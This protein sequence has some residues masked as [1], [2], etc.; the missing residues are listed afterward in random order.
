M[1][2]KRV[3]EMSSQA[4]SFSQGLIMGLGF[5]GALILG[6]YQVAMGEVTVGRFTTLLV[7]WAQLSGEIL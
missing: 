1:K 5:F 7:Y 4:I 3:F 6:G 2:S